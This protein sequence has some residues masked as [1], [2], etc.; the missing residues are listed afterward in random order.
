MT[1]GTLLPRAE[2]MA[3]TL[4]ATQ[5]NRTSRLA[6]VLSHKQETATIALGNKMLPPELLFTR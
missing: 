3:A 2:E 5:F 1:F 6:V 4:A